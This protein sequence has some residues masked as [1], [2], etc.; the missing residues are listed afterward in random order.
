[1][2]MFQSPFK[3]ANAASLNKTKSKE[4]YSAP[5]AENGSKAIRI[6]EADNQTLNQENTKSDISAAKQSDLEKAIDD[7]IIL[8]ESDG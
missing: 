5:I 2:G 4:T 6:V 3:E 8:T 7:L 1:M